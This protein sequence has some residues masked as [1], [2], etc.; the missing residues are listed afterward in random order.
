MSKYEAPVRDMRFVL[1]DV[2]GV[3]PIYQR[4]G[5]EAATRDVIEAVL[6]EAARFTGQVLAPLNKSGDEEGCHWDKGEVRTPKG[7]K[8]A[9]DQF[10][11]GGWSGLVAEP[12]YGGQGLPESLGAAARRT[13]EE[14]LTDTR[15]AQQTVE[16]Y[17]TVLQKGSAG[18]RPPAPAVP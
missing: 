2:L 4:L 6:D 15:V 13:V 17:G 8:Q 3:E 12:E 18:K 16:L 11:A 1:F 9:Y 7:F 5:Y 10:V 14:R